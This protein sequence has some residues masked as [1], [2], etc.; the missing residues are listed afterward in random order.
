MGEF[1]LA[2]KTFCVNV[3]AHSWAEAEMFLRTGFPEGKIVGEDIHE[4]S[5]I[6]PM[7]LMDFI[8]GC[9]EEPV[10]WKFNAEDQ[11]QAFLGMAWKKEPDQAPAEE[12]PLASER[13]GTDLIGKDLLTGRE[14]FRED[15]NHGV[16]PKCGKRSVISDMPS[17]ERCLSC[18]WRD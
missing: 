4:V 13:K 5:A 11:L 9:T 17:E 12:P 14:I 8:S 2:D 3:P 16:C 10:K 1:K 7:M 6:S 18:G 15:P